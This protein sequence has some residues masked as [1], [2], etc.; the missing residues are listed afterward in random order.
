MIRPRMSPRWLSL[1]WSAWA[2]VTA[3]SYI[4]VSPEPL[5]PV[6][7]LIP[8]SSL[9]WA[10]AFV[11]AL[12]AVGAALPPR[13]GRVGRVG[14]AARAVGVTLLAAFLCAWAATY[15]I[16]SI[17]DGGRLWVSAKNYFALAIAAAASAAHIA[18]NRAP[19]TEVIA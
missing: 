12:L 1:G 5:T 8:G 19:I 7:A 17:V 3:A 11:A 6:T 14:R 15:A 4:G 9:S 2:S 18:R 13:P 10:W 16:D